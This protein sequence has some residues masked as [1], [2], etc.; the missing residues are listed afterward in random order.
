MQFDKCR[1][2]FYHH[3]FI[4]MLVPIPL[5]IGL[6]RV[7]KSYGSEHSIFLVFFKFTPNSKPCSCNFFSKD[8]FFGLE[9]VIL[10]LGLLLRA[11]S[12]CELMI[13]CSSESLGWKE[14][15]SVNIETADL[16]ISV[17]ETSFWGLEEV[18]LRKKNL[19]FLARR[20]SRKKFFR[21]VL[22][23]IL[24]QGCG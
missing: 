5:E 2:L 3:Y 7:R 4:Q 1:T 24:V 9:I 8:R 20:D 22:K 13:K 18:D 14:A 6:I 10:E 21:V 12:W 17:G 11:L 16:K 15:R 19:C 23:T